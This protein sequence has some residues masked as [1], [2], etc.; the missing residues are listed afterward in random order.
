MSDYYH[1]CNRD[2]SDATTP[3]DIHEDEPKTSYRVEEQHAGS[4]QE[5][6]Y[7]DGADEVAKVVPR[8]LSQGYGVAVYVRGE[9]FSHHW[10]LALAMDDIYEGVS[11]EPFLRELLAASVY[12]FISGEGLTNA[13]TD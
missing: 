3:V 10:Y 13:R 6:H 5:V 8:I 9:R 2:E 4:T 7:L 11:V 12:R 1:H